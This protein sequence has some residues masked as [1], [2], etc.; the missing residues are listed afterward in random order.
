M[1]KLK[2][3]GFKVFCVEDEGEWLFEELPAIC[4]VDKYVARADGNDTITITA[5]VP[6]GVS[7]VDFIN[8][9]NGNVLDT[10]PVTN[11]KAIL[12]LKSNYPVNI[13]VRV[14]NET[15]TRYNEV[16]VIFE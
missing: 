10:V 9:S 16:G 5:Q 13:V 12:E 7:Y 6:S 14:G 8:V 3:N 2:I 15:K 4:T 11:G 1:A